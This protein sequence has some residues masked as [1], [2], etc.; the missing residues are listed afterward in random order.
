[1]DKRQREE[2]TSEIEITVEK[3]RIHTQT[4]AECVMLLVDTKEKV[5]SGVGTMSSV[6]A[7]FGTAIND[8]Y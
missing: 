3:Y 5:E 2:A 4:L 6:S 1:M 7:L 8:V